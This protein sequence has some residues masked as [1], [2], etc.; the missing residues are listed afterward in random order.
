MLWLAAGIDNLKPYNKNRFHL[1][2]MSYR[3][4]NEK[5]R[6]ISYTFYILINLLI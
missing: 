5:V 2:D 1:L 4:K 6:D 3:V